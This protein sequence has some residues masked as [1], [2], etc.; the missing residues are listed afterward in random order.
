MFL[1]SLAAIIPAIFVIA[2]TNPLTKLLILYKKARLALRN[3]P[4]GLSIASFDLRNCAMC[5]HW[6]IEEQDQSS[7]AK[8]FSNI[9]N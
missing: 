8:Q 5:L 1:T 7:I 4:K 3:G 6:P 2:L 9:T